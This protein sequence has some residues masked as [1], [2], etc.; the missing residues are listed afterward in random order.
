MGS[1]SVRNEE[2]RSEAR[3]LRKAR[4][5]ALGGMMGALGVLI[6]IAFHAVGGAGPVFLPMFLPVS[7]RIFFIF[8]MISRFESWEPWEKLILATSI[9]ASPR[10][11]RTSF[12]QE[13]GPMVQTILVLLL[14]EPIAIFYRN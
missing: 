4:D 5:L 9:P 6:P 7:L 3:L 8:P 1:H 12:E 10:A 14:M 11:S 2:G 13:A